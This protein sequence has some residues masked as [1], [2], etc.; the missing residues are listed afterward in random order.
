MA[1]AV[2]QILHTLIVQ[3]IIVDVELGTGIGTLSSTESDVDKVFAEDTVEDAVTPVSV[4]LPDFVNH[5][6]R[7]K[8]AR[9]RSKT[10]PS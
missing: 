6:L 4:I 5:I 7:K 3:V 9:V 2:L 1:H 10:E 8:S